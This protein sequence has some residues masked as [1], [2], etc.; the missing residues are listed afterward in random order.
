MLVGLLP[1]ACVIT[2]GHE[3]SNLAANQVTD[4]PTGKYSGTWKNTDRPKG[5]PQVLG[6]NTDRPKG[7]YSGTLNFFCKSAKTMTS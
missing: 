7:K 2:L 5:K 3:S 6:K 1:P 4:R